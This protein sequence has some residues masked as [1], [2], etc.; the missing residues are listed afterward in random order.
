MLGVTMKASVVL[1]ALS[2]ALIVSEAHAQRYSL[3]PHY[4]VIT[5]KLDSHPIPKK[6][7]FMQVVKL[8]PEMLAA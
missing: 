6:S 4:G 5:L 1:A 7:P 2:T 3:D 8:M